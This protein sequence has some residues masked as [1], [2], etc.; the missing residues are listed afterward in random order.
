[1][2]R[3]KDHI[4]SKQLRTFVLV[5]DE[6]TCRICGF[7]VPEGYLFFGSELRGLHLDHIVSVAD[8]GQTV[9]E[10]L[11]VLCSKCNAIKAVNSDLDEAYIV[12]RSRQIDQRK[13][14]KYASYGDGIK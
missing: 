1:M 9:A 13:V 8:G 14:R 3:S 4:P 7:V 11:R 2:R 12:E 10:N 6:R 5:R